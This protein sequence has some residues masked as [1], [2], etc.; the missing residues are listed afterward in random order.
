MNEDEKK[1]VNKMIRIYCKLRHKTS[2]G[3]CNQCLELR[4]YAM[5]RL[6]KCPFGEKKPTCE[7]CSIHCYKDNMRQ[8]IREV[9][10]F[11]GPRMIFVH[12]KDA[13]RHLFQKT[14]R[15]KRAN[16]ISK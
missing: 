4:N 9:M 1:V 5:L 16:S 12:P 7:S 6:E 13:I 2:S 3:L 10:R 15:V 8:E 11:A 14:K